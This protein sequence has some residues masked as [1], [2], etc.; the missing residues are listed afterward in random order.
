MRNEP[1]HK[2]VYLKKFW[3]LD[4]CFPF[5]P[6]ESLEMSGDEKPIRGK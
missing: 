4:D 6:Y 3:K 2:I 1:L 5:F